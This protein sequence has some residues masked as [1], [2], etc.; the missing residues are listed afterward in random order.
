MD[1]ETSFYAP[2]FLKVEL[3]CD[4]TLSELDSVLKEVLGIE[5]VLSIEIVSLHV[6]K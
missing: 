2:I 3:S 1:K 4:L 6:S 5:G